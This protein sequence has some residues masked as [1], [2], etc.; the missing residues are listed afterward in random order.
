M[1][2]PFTMGMDNSD[3]VFFGCRFRTRDSFS[4]FRV[5]C[6]DGL[7]NRLVVLGTPLCF[8]YLQDLSCF[9]NDQVGRA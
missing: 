9:R 5:D 2:G 4:F 8:S 3:I 6:A 1:K 7:L